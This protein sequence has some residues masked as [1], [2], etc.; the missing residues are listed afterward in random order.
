[1]PDRIVRAAILTSERVDRLDEGA[2]NFYRRL[3]N[4]VDD[5]GRFDARPIVLRTALYPIRSDSHVSTSLENITAR[6]Q[7][8]AAAGLVILYEVT[9]KPYGIL[10]NLGAPRAR[11]SRF[12]DPPRT[13]VRAHEIICPQ[14]QA[15]VPY[16]N[17][18]SN[19]S[20]NALSN[21]LIKK[22]GKSARRESG[23]NPPQKR[24]E[25]PKSAA[26]RLAEEV[27]SRHERR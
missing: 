8:C 22:N 21:S 3:L 12:P 23:E 19:S 25:G 5:Y 6:L 18:Y 27:R 10:L 15:Y 26:E 14:T 4:V 24:I 16:S 17:S 13:L 20:S 11:S 1:M 7:Q 2:E 9:Q